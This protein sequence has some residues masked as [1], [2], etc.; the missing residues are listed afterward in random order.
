MATKEVIEKLRNELNASIE[1]A[2]ELTQK[3][4]L[5]LSQK[6]DKE[7]NKFHFGGDEKR[8]NEER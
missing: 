4:V 3:E 6:L 1:V 2:E 5:E 8:D 7:I